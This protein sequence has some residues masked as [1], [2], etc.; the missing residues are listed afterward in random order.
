MLLATFFP[1]LEWCEIWFI[2][3]QILRAI[4]NAGLVRV[5]PAQPPWNLDEEDADPPS[6]DGDPSS[7]EVDEAEEEAK[8]EFD[9]STTSTVLCDVVRTITAMDRT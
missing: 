2:V 6:P 5:P 3:N 9:D 4:L 1:W 8:E 7:E